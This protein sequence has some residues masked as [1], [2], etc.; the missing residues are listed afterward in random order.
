[1]ST[2]SERFLKKIYQILY[3]NLEKNKKLKERSVIKSFLKITSNVRFRFLKDS[4]VPKYKIPRDIFNDL[5][6]KKLIRNT[7][8]V[9][10]YTLTLKGIWEVEN[11]NNIMSNDILLEFLDKSFFNVYNISEKP[12]S[13]K[14]KVI[15]FSMIA[16]R[17]FSEKSSVDL[18][19]G[20][21]A[22]NSWEE[23]I[24]K[25][26][27]K[28]KSLPLISKLEQEDLYGKPGNEHKV[29][30]LFRHTDALPKKTGGLFKAVGKQK[31]FL[32]LFKEEI[33]KEN[34]IY[35]L[36]QILG[37]KIL[38]MKEIN[39]IDTFCR[40]IAHNKNIFIFNAKEHIFSKPEVDEVIRDALL[41][42]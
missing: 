41:L 36:K 23:I 17:A 6:D 11:K 13:E 25:S 29:S 28:M 21:T 31:Y 15:I 30:S 37:E 4:S 2:D 5:I 35:L 18:K 9:D 14:E 38:S 33:A 10:F 22:L 1:M 3:D 19:K 40:D 26:Y 8:K 20:E 12:L 24:N 34:L 32:D 42:S 7:D 27:E 39:D 16:A